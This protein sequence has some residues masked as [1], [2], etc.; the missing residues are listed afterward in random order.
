[1][2]AYT[3]DRAIAWGDCDAFGIVFYPNFMAWCDETFHEMA[4]ANGFGHRGLPERGIAGTPLRDIGATFHSP[5]T[6]G[7]VLTIAATVSDIG[8][9]SFRMNYRLTLGERLVAETH[10]VRVFT[11]WTKGRLHGVEIP[12]DIR[13]RLEALA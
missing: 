7:D 2:T 8:R 9:S 5:A 1:M 10:E 4:A 12:D 3:R 11:A 6:Y 13:A